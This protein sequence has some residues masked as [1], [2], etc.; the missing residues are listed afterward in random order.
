MASMASLG[1][2]HRTLREAAAEEI[3]ALILKGELA[4]GERLVEDRLASQ[5]GVSRNPVREAIRLLESTGLVQVLPRR[6]A[7]VAT[8]DVDDL[9]QLLEMRA[10]IEGYAAEVA[11]RQ[12]S[13]EGA[14]RLGDVIATGREATEQGDIVRAAA[15]HRE[16]HL[17]IERMAGNRYLTEVAAP[18][19]NRTELVFSLLLDTR[20]GVTW[21]E[22]QAIHD[23]IAAGEPAAARAA[24]DAHLT[25]VRRALRALR[26]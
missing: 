7:Y 22:H 4:P 21:T 9:E 16:F 17:E 10:V 8:V 26:T 2:T 24:V 1:E 13:G 6:G 25:S 14:A 12:G 23:A 11:A 3:H 18:L 19:R 5:L 15:C 20:Q